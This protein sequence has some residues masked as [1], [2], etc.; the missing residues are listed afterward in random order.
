MGGRFVASE[1]TNVAELLDSARKPIRAR[2]AGGIMP[3]YRFGLR[4][5]PPRPTS[6]L[7]YPFGSLRVTPLLSQ[8]RHSLRLYRPVGLEFVRAAPAELPHSA[9]SILNSAF[10]GFCISLHFVGTNNTTI[11]KS[12]EK[13]PPFSPPI[14]HIFPI[15]HIPTP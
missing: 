9:I 12:E 1:A 8:L 11:R 6:G 15:F 2:I 5:M 7:P 4:F 14:I 10:P 3:C 13:T